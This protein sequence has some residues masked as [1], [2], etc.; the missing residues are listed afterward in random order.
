M[1]FMSLRNSKRRRGRVGRSCRARCLLLCLAALGRVTAQTPPA[2]TAAEPA[3]LSG[4]VTNSVTGAPVLR[5]HVSI[6]NS[7]GPEQRYGAVTNGEGKFTMTHLSPGHYTVSVERA[8]FVMLR[9]MA[10]RSFTD[11]KL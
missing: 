3:S 8:G 2:A 11:V 10:G 4:A 7:S 6:R 5:A 1:M 9:N